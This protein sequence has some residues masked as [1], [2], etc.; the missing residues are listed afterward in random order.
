VLEKPNVE[1]I[2]AIGIVI[3]TMQDGILFDYILV[4][5][6]DGVACEHRHTTWKPKF[7]MEKKKEKLVWNRSS[8]VSAVGGIKV[9]H[10]WSILETC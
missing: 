5:H 3:W 1:P 4:T 7:H 8:I 9:C 10:N 2:I 6:N